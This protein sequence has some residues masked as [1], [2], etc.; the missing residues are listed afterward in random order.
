V[1]EKVLREFEAG[2][3]EFSEV[4]QLD[5]KPYMRMMRPFVTEKSCLKCHAIQGYKEG[6]VRGGLSV[7]IPLQPLLDASSSQIRGILAFNGVI[8]L[9]G[10]SVTGLGAR[11]L[12]RS[13]RVQKRIEEEL[14]QQAALLEEEIAERQMAQESLQESEAHMRI[15]ADYSSNWEYWRLD[16]NSFLYISPSVVKLTGYSI[17]EFMDDR[18]LMYRIIHP[19]DLDLFRHH[20]HEVDTSGQILPIEMR[21]VAKSGE[22][23]W[24]GHACQRVFNN[25]GMPWGWRASNQDITAL[26]QLEHEL[27]EQTRQLKDEVAERETAQEELKQLNH[28]LEQ[29]ITTSVSELRLKDQTLIQQGRLAAMGDDQ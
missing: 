11:Q 16:D 13:A 8:W 14:H 29:R 4:T 26:K 24:M 22:V 5:G 20:T 25:D 12:S 3:K 10:L 19:D 2:T 21:I 9:I 23:R 15:V 6:D 17:D 27:F 1:G 7:S 18:E 28:Y